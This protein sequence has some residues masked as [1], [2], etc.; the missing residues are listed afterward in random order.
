MSDTKKLRDWNE[1]PNW[2]KIQIY[3]EIKQNFLKEMEKKEIS[4]QE[5]NLEKLLSGLE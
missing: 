5:E 2:E 1:V 3:K 4:V